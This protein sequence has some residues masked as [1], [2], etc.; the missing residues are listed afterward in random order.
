MRID[1][2][3]RVEREESY[4]TAGSMLKYSFHVFS[5]CRYFQSIQVLN[6]IGS[7]TSTDVCID[8]GSSFTAVAPSFKRGKMEFLY[9]GVTTVIWMATYFVELMS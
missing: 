4:S 7:R 3:E 1:E 2:I 8:N 5:I 6:T 9:S